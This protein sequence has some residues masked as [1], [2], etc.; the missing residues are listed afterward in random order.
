MGNFKVS[1]NINTTLQQINAKNHSSRAGSQIHD[2]S[3]KNL[4]PKPLDQGSYP[5]TWNVCLRFR[6]W[7][8]KQILDLRYAEI[9]HSDWFYIV[10]WNSQSKCFISVYLCYSNICLWHRVRSSLWRTEWLIILRR[11][12]I[13]PFIFRLFCFLTMTEL[14]RWF[15]YFCAAKNNDCKIFFFCL[16]SWW[17][18]PLPTWVILF[19]INGKVH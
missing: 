11:D 18:S 1:S 13:G 2:L 7:S 8:H 9:R 14:L 6:F 3:N 12:Y 10:T 16:P 19:V 17:H 5:Y 15:P 4:L